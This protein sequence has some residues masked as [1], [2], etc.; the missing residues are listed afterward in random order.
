MSGY[1]R[2]DV[3]VNMQ[4]ETAIYINPHGQIVVRQTD[5]RDQLS[6]RR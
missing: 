6:R 3:V 2:R 4:P 1:G 5:V